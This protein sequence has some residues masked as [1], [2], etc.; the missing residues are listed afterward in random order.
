[1]NAGKPNLNPA[2]PL[3]YAGFIYF[4]PV[5]SEFSESSVLNGFFSFAEALFERA[6]REVRLLFIDQ[7]R[8]RH[9]DGILAR[10]ENQQSFVERFADDRVAQV[11]GFFLGF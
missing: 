6:N 1:M 5:N 8:R 9:A 2:P 11:R 7:Q 4:F 10:A 3:G